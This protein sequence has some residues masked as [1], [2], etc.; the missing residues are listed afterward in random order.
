MWPF[1]IEHWC[2]IRGTA[3][4]V[5][6]SAGFVACSPHSYELGKDG[7][8]ASGEG[9]DSVGGSGGKGGSGKGGTGNKGGTGGSGT[10]LGG[11]SGTAGSKGGGK[12]GGSGGIGASGGSSAAGGGGTIDVS[13]PLLMQ[14]SNTPSKLDLLFMIDNSIG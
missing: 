2:G 4:L 3:W 8:G 6:L 1:M 11:S 5:A 9:G 12:T 14:L 10:A 13:D 7:T